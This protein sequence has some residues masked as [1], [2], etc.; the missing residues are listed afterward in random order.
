RGRRQGLHD[1]RPERHHPGGGDPHQRNPDEPRAPAPC[2]ISRSP[3]LSDR[4]FLCHGPDAAQRQAE[5]RL[6]VRSV[7]IE[8]GVLAPGAPE[9][10]ELMRRIAST[11]PTVRMPL[12]EA[13]KRPLSPEE[14]ALVEQWIAEGAT[15]EPH[16]AFTPPMRPEVPEVENGAWCRNPI[17]RFIL[18]RLEAEGIEP[19]ADAGGTGRLPCGR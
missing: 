9:E 14:Q 3:L 6:D 16:W 4:C 7:A 5:L 2:L 18:A 8:R 19:S 13:N 1:G 10:S 17:D 11:D 15:Y 12:P